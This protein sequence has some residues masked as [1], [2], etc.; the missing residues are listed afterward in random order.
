MTKMSALERPRILGDLDAN[1]AKATAQARTVAEKIG[2]SLSAPYVL[3][4]EH[5]T[6]EPETVKHRCSA[7]IGVVLYLGTLATLEDI[8]KW[9][10][11]AMYQAKAAG[12]NAIR[13]YDHGAL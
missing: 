1:L 7:S 12:R 11:A 3:S 6:Q 13:F 10:D 2:T 4:V 9:A 5:A 8:F